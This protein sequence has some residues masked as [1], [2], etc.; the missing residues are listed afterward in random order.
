VL[1]SKR[2]ELPTIS[3]FISRS[4]SINQSHLVLSLQTQHAR[5]ISSVCFEPLKYEVLE[6]VEL[7]L[8][9]IFLQGPKIHKRLQLN[10]YTSLEVG[11]YRQ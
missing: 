6:A 5:M 10:P 2:S 3:Q 1:D 7:V 4:L 11:Q 8:G 9:S